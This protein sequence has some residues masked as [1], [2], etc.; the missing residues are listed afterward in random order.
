MSTGTAGIA[1]TAQEMRLN[2][3]YDPNITG[4]GHQPYGFD[5]FNVLYG[6]YK[7]TACLVD[8]LFTT[9]GGTADI[10]CM[11]LVQS[12]SGGLSLTGI[13]TDRAVEMPQI[14]TAHLSSSGLRTARIRK[15]FPLHAVFGLTPGQFD[16][17]VEDYA[18]AVGSN[19][20]R[21]AVLAF[22]ISSYSGVGSEASSVR[23]L[24][25]YECELW[26][27]VQQAQS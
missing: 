12:P 16:A 23:C 6:K 17:N 18:A 25:S 2:S 26:D 22:A 19:P 4:T 27:R 11:A 14:A 1:G 20:T 8:L 24:L 15:R 21:T 5:N 13:S 9:P 3:L 10:C 7:V